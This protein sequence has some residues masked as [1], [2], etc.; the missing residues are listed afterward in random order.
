MP[1]YGNATKEGNCTGENC[2]LHQS[3]TVNH[4]YLYQLNALKGN[5]IYQIICM[6]QLKVHGHNGVLGAL[7][8]E[9]V[10]VMQNRIELEVSVVEICLVQEAILL[11]KAALV[12]H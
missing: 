5:L 9:H 4:Y 1:C 2:I 6:F 12:R 10:T 3:V 7:A 11:D 8:W